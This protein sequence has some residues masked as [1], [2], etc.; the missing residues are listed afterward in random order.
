MEE[1]KF[2]YEFA[3]IGGGSGGIAC[4]KEAGKLLGPGK[5]VLF[6][7]VQPTPIGTKWGV[8]GTCVNVGCIPKKLM[9]TAALYGH[10]IKDSHDYGWKGISN[11]ELKN[12]WETLQTN[13][14]YH[15][16]SINWGYKRTNLP[17]NNVK[18]ETKYARFVDANTIEA[19]DAKGVKQNIT[20]KKIVIACGGRPRYP[21]IPGAK[22]FGI[23][24]DDIFWKTTPPG[25]T[26][27]VGASYVALECA[28]FIKHLGFDVTVMVRSVLLRGFDQE[29]AN[30]IG[31][32]LE[33]SGVNMMRKCVPTKL[34]KG[35][36]GK[37]KVYFDQD[38]KTDSEPLEYDTV[39]FAIGRDPEVHKLNVKNIGLELKPNGKIPAKEE[40]TNVPSV[41]AIGDCVYGIPELTPIAI[42]QG[43]F[44]CQRLFGTQPDKHRMQWNYIPT[45][46]FTPLEYGCIGMT[47]EDAIS[48][49]GADN[50]EVYHSYFTPLEW[51]VP[52]RP[53]NKCF[54]KL[55]VN[56]ADKGRVVGFH[57]L[58]VHAGEIT[59]GY[60]LGMKLGATFDD[61]THLVGIHPTSAEEFTTLDKTKRSGADPMKSGC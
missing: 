24:S 55:I 33:S 1:K 3:V 49:H 61:F 59:Q 53:E 26:L 41:Y 38:G 56:L 42:Q 57:V 12:D 30:L 58:G 35:E 52:H 6:D 9:H 7:F 32:D 43:K 34:E 48:Q 51:T 13:V 27:V 17:D 14:G 28:G 44:L 29:I 37:V 16:R 22:E 18:L 60:A 54:A 45:T 50:V 39:M 36:N 4:A 15:I 5:T 23:T 10:I 2:D 11:E 31:A 8:G 25:K 20:A 47:E 40:Q 19:E 46:V 21:D